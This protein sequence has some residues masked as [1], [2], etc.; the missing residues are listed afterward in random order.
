M[1]LLLSS[2]LIKS[3]TYLN[4]QSQTEQTIQASCRTFRKFTPNNWKLMYVKMA[5]YKCTEK[6]L[7]VIIS[8][9]MLILKVKMNYNKYNEHTIQYEDNDSSLLPTTWINAT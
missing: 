4:S 7:Y 9:N 2:G 8:Y 1:S 5:F 3:K 6:L